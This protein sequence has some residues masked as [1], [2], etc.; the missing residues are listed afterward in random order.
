MFNDLYK[1]SSLVSTP[2]S[3]SDSDNKTRYLQAHGSQAGSFESRVS[4]H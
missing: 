1:E 3:L 2:S 4:F